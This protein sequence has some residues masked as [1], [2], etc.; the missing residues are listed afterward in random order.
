MRYVITACLLI[1]ASNLRAA[2]AI[3]QA[4]EVYH[5]IMVEQT[6]EEKLRENL[7]VFLGTDDVIASVKVTLLSSRVRTATKRQEFALP[8]VPVDAE[9]TKKKE[10]KIRQRM[11]NISATVIVGVN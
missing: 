4:T 10:T 3:P 5:K 7:K 11:G 6:L 8:G 9:L 2:E 1:L